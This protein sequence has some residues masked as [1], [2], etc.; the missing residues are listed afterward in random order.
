MN[1]AAAR[2]LGAN[3]IL[4]ADVNTARLKMA[5]AMGADEVVDV[6][7]EEAA[8]RVMASTGGRGADVVIEYSARPE[9]I[10]MAGRA[11]TPGGELR[12]LGV[13]S[14]EFALDL[15]P[16]LFKGV[17]VRS[18]H[19]RRLFSS[20][21][22]ATNLL[23]DRKVSIEPLISDRLPLS[24]AKAGFEKAVGGTG[25]KVMFQCAE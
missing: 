1:I 22:H 18:L 25:I 8:A 7:K 24:D 6:S 5:L 4:A 11:V 9:S 20:W 2:A 16:W 14:G 17:I 21:E 13:P 15:N 23:V 10:A 3:R 12:L 19:G